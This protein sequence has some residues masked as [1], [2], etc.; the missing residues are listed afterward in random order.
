MTTSYAQIVNPQPKNPSPFDCLGTEL[1][2]EMAS[3][4][5]NMLYTSC[6][7]WAE[8]TE[9][10]E[11]ALENFTA[12]DM[13]RGLNLVADGI[14]AGNITNRYV[15]EAVKEFYFGNYDAS[16]MDVVAIDIV[17]QY[18]LFGKLMFN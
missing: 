6:D 12:E 15:V 18:A 7:Y 3:D 2:Q 1:G 16:F 4:M 10:I 8:E 13:V 11:Q 17:V 9:E 14:F 5:L